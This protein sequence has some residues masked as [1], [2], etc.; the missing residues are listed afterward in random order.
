MDLAHT[1]TAKA[2]YPAKPDVELS[3]GERLV[4]GGG[5]WMIRHADG[6]YTSLPL[7]ARTVYAMQGAGHSTM[8]FDDMAR[9]NWITV[10]S[11]ILAE[12]EVVE[13]CWFKPTLKV[14]WARADA[15][16]M[17]AE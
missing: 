14:T 10:Y 2:P 4:E 16:A 9:R 6:R 7:P 3:P 11:R 1:Q 12:G 15:L 8:L 5:G 13:D 17:A